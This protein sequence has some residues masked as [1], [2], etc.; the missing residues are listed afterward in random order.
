MPCLK[1]ARVSSASSRRRARFRDGALKA[2][3]LCRNES[4]EIGKHIG[5]RTHMVKSVVGLP[6]GWNPPVCDFIESCVTLRDGWRV[7]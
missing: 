4:V 7:R 3:L 6:L 1:T 5:R 2:I